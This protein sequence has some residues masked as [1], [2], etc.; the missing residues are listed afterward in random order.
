MPLPPWTR[1]LFSGSVEEFAGRLRRND[2]FRELQTKATDM[3]GE[4]PVTAARRLER[5]LQESR[6]GTERLRRWTRRQTSLSTLAI[7]GSGVLFHSSL[8]GVPLRTDQIDTFAPSPDLFQ[9]TRGAV[10]QRITGRLRAALGE[11]GD[12]DIAVARSTAAAA[13]AVGAFASA[14]GLALAVPRSAAMRLEGGRPLPEMLAAGGCR[15][16]EVGG[17]DRCTA[18]DWDQVGVV[19]GEHLAAVTVEW[20]EAAQRSHSAAARAD[21]CAPHGRRQVRFLP[22]GSFSSV[23]GLSD[24]WVS[25]LHGRTLEP[26]ALTVLPGDRLVGGPRSGIIL[27][28]SDAIAA[29]RATALWPA[30]EADLPSMAAL[31]LAMERSSGPADEPPPVVAMLETSVENLQNRCERLATQLVGSQRVTSCQI[32]A[33]DASLVEGDGG[34]V[35]SRQIRVARS[36]G[37]AKAWAETLAAEA[38]ALLVQ[39]EEEAI[40][41]DLRWIPPS[42]DSELV[43]LLTE[44]PSSELSP[45]Y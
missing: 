10:R 3:L 6:R 39:S 5:I 32:T 4:L 24:S 27:G 16:I 33:A 43:R 28:S 25:N 13:T 9:L 40:V 19:A 44:L 38:P 30:L 17:P 34:G 15:V 37:G 7:N 35:P 41:I 14:T 1:E 12:V 8:A 31:V 36:S 29:I 23:P 45:E 11:R 22:L 42:V 2:S 20:P 21:W 18:D 26:R